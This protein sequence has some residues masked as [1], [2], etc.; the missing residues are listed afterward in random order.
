ME[1]NLPLLPTGHV[2]CVI[3]SGEQ[4]NHRVATW[5]DEG[6]AAGER[7][8]VVQAADDNAGLLA[9]LRDHGIDAEQAVLD[10]RLLLLVPE[11][12]YL[13]NGV[14]DLDRRIEESRLFIEQSVAEG[15]TAVRLASDADLVLGVVGDM[16]ALLAYERRVEVLSRAVPVSRICFYDR[17]VFGPALASFVAA[18]PR[19]AADAQL[20]GAGEPGHLRLSGDVDMSNV[21]LLD[22]MLSSASSDE[23]N[24]VV[25]LHAVTFS[26]LAG[27]RAL[28]AASRRL[29][30]GRRLKVLSA[31]RLLFTMVETIGWSDNLDLV[32]GE[33]AA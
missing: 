32:V 23:G 33:A 12:V 18:H 26:D 27:A 4:R 3:E 16:D 31:P 28:V 2:C 19:G 9:L 20:A 22:A 17:A 29:S 25:D 6:L 10:G 24:V 30:G 14:F 1:A 8:V 21:D 5:T 11:D 7:V 15:Y 13:S